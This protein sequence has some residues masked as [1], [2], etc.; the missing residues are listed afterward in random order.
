MWDDRDM[1]EH[2]V[3]DHKPRENGII[4]Y[5]NHH[6]PMGINERIYTG[7]PMGGNGVPGGRITSPGKKHE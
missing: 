5:H 7:L 3:F 4:Q 6:L 2:T 1:D